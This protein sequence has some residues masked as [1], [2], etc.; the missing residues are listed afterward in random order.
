[1]VRRYGR[2]VTRRRRVVRRRRVIRRR[3]M[4]RKPGKNTSYDGVY[5]AK[6]FTTV[7]IKVGE[8]LDDDGLRYSD[9]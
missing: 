3:T 8:L 4:M 1:M 6:C 9:Y 7:P 5:Y 2:R